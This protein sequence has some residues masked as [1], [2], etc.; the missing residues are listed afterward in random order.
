MHLQC[1]QG[2]LYRIRFIHV[3]TAQKVPE[4]ENC[5]SHTWKWLWVF[6]S[7]SSPHNTWRQI[8]NYGKIFL[9]LL[10]LI[11]W[12]DKHSKCWVTGQIE[13]LLVILFSKVDN[14]TWPPGPQP[15]LWQMK[16]AHYKFR[17]LSAN[18]K[19]S[20]PWNTKQ[21]E[22]VSVCIHKLWQAPFLCVAT[23]C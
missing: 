8:Q 6:H 16:L 4:F 22:C 12:S 2:Q 15:P 1:V 7:T 3:S 10:L 20:R 21:G 11:F 9:H 5:S 19:V 17:H 23:L 14:T 13:C 18:C